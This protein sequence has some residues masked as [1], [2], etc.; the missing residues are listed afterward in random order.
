MVSLRGLI[1]VSFYDSLILFSLVSCL[2]LSMC[3]RCCKIVCI[4]CFHRVVPSNERG[5][6][7]TAPPVLGFSLPVWEPERAVR[8]SH[9]FPHC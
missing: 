6:R 7:T 2:V 1:F 3:T 9:A 4:P 8:S 5:V